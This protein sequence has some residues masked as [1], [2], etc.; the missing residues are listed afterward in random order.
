MPADTGESGNVGL[1]RSERHVCGRSGHRL[2]NTIVPKE[3]CLGYVGRVLD[4]A[5]LFL[6]G[7]T[8]FGR[9][10]ADSVPDP[11]PVLQP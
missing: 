2:L 11:D 1:E 3:S 8:V 9:A 5:C 6:D 7:S 10:I 4:H